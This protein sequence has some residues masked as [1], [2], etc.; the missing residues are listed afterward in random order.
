ME[1]P[2]VITLDYLE[3]LDKGEI[4]GD[5][6]HYGMLCLTKDKVFKM[7][8]ESMPDVFKRFLVSILH[9]NIRPKDCI[10][11]FKDKELFGT[12]SIYKKNIVDFNVAINNNLFVNLEVNGRPY[13][14]VKSRNYLYESRIITSSLDEGD[15]YNSF[16]DNTYIQLNLNAVDKTTFGED[17]VYFCS[18]ITKT[19]YFE[20]M[21]TYVRYLEYYRKLYYNQNIEKDESDYWLA[22]L[23]AKNFVELYKMLDDFL[24]TKT[25]DRIIKRVIEISMKTLFTEEEWKALDKLVDENEKKYYDKKFKDKFEEGMNQGFDQ[26]LEQGTRQG[27]EQSKIQVAKNLLS[28]NLTI[29]QIIEATGLSE[30]EVLKLSKNKK[31]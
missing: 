30:E 16:D 27:I 4:I 22:S 25:R 28:M 19:V 23:T 12:S 26:G 17:I 15:D 18:V 29:E 13:E 10:L 11:T 5:N 1:V 14:Q 31:A 7:L 21:I 24:E 8:F 20:N 2:S 6:G 9:L 3:K